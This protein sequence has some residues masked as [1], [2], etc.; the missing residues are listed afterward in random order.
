MCTH[1]HMHRQQQLAAMNIYVYFAKSHLIDNWVSSWSEWSSCSGLC[2]GGSK[3][4]SRVV[5]VH[6]QYGGQPCPEEN[7]EMEQ[8]T[9][10]A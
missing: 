4:R 1:T 7:N 3:S 5:D 2:G 6:A 10:R 9:Q 8:C